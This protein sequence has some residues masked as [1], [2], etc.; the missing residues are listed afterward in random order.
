MLTKGDDFPIHQ[1]P[2][3]IA[4]SGTDRNFYDRYFFNGYQPDGTEFFAIGFGVYPHLNI[5]DAHFSVIRDGIEHC[6][7]ASR[8]LNME[9]MDISAGPIR[10]EVVE[11]LKVL[12]V[13]VEAS[14]G[15]AADLTFEGR[16]FPIEEPRFV[17]RNGPRAFMDYTRL[18]VNVRVS[19]W[20]EVDGVRRTLAPGSV[21]TRDRSWGVR[22]VGAP[23]PQPIVPN[24]IPSFFW[25]WTPLNFEDRSVFFHVNADSEGEPWNTRAVILPDGAGPSGGRH[26]SEA[27]MEDVVMIPGTRH[28]ASATLSI[29]LAQ[30]SA[31]VSFQPFLTFLM[32]GIGYGHPE[33]RHGGYKGELAVD[34]E[35]IDLS[36]VNFLSPENL[37]IQALSHVTLTL[38][39]EAPVRGMGVFEQLILGPYRP[40][41]LG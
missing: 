7:H 8:V 26:T 9:R 18:T 21:G 35:D 37:H 36:K 3:P 40:Y 25:Q 22:P 12:R 28:I 17:Y 6:L 32:R 11:P 10:I 19:G 13:V 23:D 2:E 39:G 34:R 41:G 30:G 14:H 27:A 4:F 31:K 15:I 29:P 20:I 1:T 24:R 38:P 5:A 16:T 33:W